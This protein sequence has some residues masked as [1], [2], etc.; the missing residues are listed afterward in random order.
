MKKLRL[1][2][3]LETTL[4]RVA[5]FTAHYKVT[6]HWDIHRSLSLQYMLTNWSNSKGVR[7]TKHGLSVFRAKNSYR[8]E[9]DDAKQSDNIPAL[10]ERCQLA[11]EGHTDA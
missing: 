3:E 1:G 7:F 4:K 8:P 11:Q 6:H 9:S 5:K 2:L 10:E